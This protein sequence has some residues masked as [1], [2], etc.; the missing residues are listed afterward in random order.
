MGEIQEEVFV[1]QTPGFEDP[2]F[3]NHVYKLTKAL[4]GLKQAPRAWYEKL[5]NLPNYNKIFLR[6]NVDK[7]LFHKNKREKIFCLSKYMLMTLFLDQQ[8]ANF[9]KIL[10]TL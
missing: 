2:N 9:V 6:G 7:K 4:Y 3:P 8:T 1:S 10:K 5:S